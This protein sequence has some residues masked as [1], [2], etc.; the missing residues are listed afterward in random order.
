VGG[1][2][3]GDTVSR[4]RQEQEDRRF[5]RFSGIVD[6]KAIQA[7][8]VN[9]IGCGGIGSWVALALGCLGVKLTLFDP[10][11]TQRHNFGGQPLGRIGV[12]KVEQLRD[13]MAGFAGQVEVV[14][15]LF[16]L[17]EASEYPAS[18]WVSGVD[19]IGARREILHALGKQLDDGKGPGWY[20][21]CRMGGTASN[22][23]VVQTSDTVAMQRYVKSLRPAGR[24][25]NNLCAQRS[26]VF[27]GMGVAAEAVGEVARI[28]RGEAVSRQRNMEWMSGMEVEGWTA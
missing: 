27:A 9:L 18:I 25:V 6:P 3:S 5:S 1:Y 4:Q 15:R 26:T 21:D 8:S 14:E 2:E 13:M 7:S 23:L 16:G 22:L 11:A 19:S 17:E 24:F 10:D 20:I 12:K 28:L